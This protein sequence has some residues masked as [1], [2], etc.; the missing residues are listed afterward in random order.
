[1]EGSRDRARPFVRSLTI[2]DRSTL[3]PD[4][5]TLHISSRLSPSFSLILSSLR[6]FPQQQYPSSISPS[7]PPPPLRSSREDS[8]TSSLAP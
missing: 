7:P 2:P 4:R 6:R 1:M 5:T 3:P 8:D